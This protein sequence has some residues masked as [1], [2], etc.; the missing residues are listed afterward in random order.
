MLK[1][2]LRKKGITYAELG[3]RIGRHPVTIAKYVTH[4]RPI[5]PSVARLISLSTGI[6]L[7]DILKDGDA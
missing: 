2:A 4:V 1:A 3:R 5:P 7:V 6:P